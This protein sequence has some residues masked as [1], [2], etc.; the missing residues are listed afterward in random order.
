M[1]PP[2]RRRSAARS[3]RTAAVA[4]LVIVSAGC[5]SATS[6]VAPAST[7]RIG[8]FPDVPSGTLPPGTAAALQAVL[9]KAVR[10]GELP[11]ISATVLVAGRGAWTGVAGTAD[12]LHPVQPSALFGIGSITKTMVAAEVMR[13]S[14]TGALGLDDPVAEHLPKGIKFDTNAATIRDLLSMRSGIPDASLIDGPGMETD[15]RRVWKPADVLASVPPSRTPPGHT[16]E[17]INVNYYLLGLVVEHETGTNLAVALRRHIL[18][19]PRLAAMA[20]QPWERPRPLA[21]PFIGSQLRPHILATGG[22]ILPTAASASVGGGAGCVVAS[23]RALAVWGYQL[24][25]GHLLSPAS[26]HAMTSFTLDHYG[27][28]VFDENPFAP[29]F[30]T[31][32]VGNGGWDPGGYS[33]VLSVLPSRGVVITVLT[34]QGGDPV[35]LVF[36]IAVALNRSLEQGS[37][38]STHD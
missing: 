34:N 26:L 6:P 21:L 1:T 2:R 22:G 10:V 30:A 29:D 8:A 36:P 4:V 35:Q 38:T 28:G 12:D 37:S 19:D 9:D 5:G 17:Y 13:L 18:A 23:S 20:V 25:G 7:Y 32:A 33:S 3:W 27:L 14:Q 31:P 16:F 15:P 24:F 11:G